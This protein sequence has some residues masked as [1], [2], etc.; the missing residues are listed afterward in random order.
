MKFTQAQLDHVRH[1]LI[2]ERDEGT[3][4]GPQQQH[5][6]RQAILIDIFEKAS[7]GHLE[8]KWGFRRTGEGQ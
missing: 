6:K 3:Y 8:I 7:T 5:A 1:L 4:W 2:C